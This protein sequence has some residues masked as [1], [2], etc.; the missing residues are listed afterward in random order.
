MS[1]ELWQRHFGG[2]AALVGR[3][4]QLDGGSY[5]VVGILPRGFRLPLEFRSRTRADI[6]VPLGL[7]PAANNGNHNYYNIARLKP[8]VTVARATSELQGL[9]RQWTADGLYPVAMQFTAF[10]VGLTD[11]VSGSVRPALLILLGA[12]ALLLLISSSNVANLLLT[13]ADARERE[14][15]IRAALGAGARRMMQVSLAES[16]V[17]ALAGGAVGLAFA[18]GGVRVLAQYASTSVPRADELGLDP[19]VV[20]FTLVLSILTGLAFGATPALRAM[21][22]NLA[23]SLREGGRSGSAGRDLAPGPRAARDRRNG[24][25]GS[26]GHRRRAAERSFRNLSQIDPGFDP[27]GVITMRMSLPTPNYPATA[28]LVRFY[29]ALGVEVRRM[30]GVQ[31]AGFVRSL[32]LGDANRRCGSLQV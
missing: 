16:M 6:L 25:R 28:D 5:S 30:P 29:D 27:R 32:P 15:G 11:E 12:V 2:D 24:A 17:L 8:G 19:A 13:R 23:G 9:A 22:V 26:A 20:A 14:M 4:I 31:A 21:R 10:S 3:T 7:D 1:Y 18:W